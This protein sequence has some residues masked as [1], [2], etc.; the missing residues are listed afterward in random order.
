MDYNEQL[1][2]NEATFK[3]GAQLVR[4]DIYMLMN[5][6]DETHVDASLVL[7]VIYA[8]ERVAGGSGYGNVTVFIENKVATFVKSD[9]SRKVNVAVLKG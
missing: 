8:L 9:E 5:A 3:K 1:K 6:L 7:S 2:H 4:P